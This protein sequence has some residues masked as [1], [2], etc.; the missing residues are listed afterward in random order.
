MLARLAESSA[1]RVRRQ[2]GMQGTRCS[3]VPA[4]GQVCDPPWTSW[5]SSCDLCRRR[6]F[7]LACAPPGSR[8]HGHVLHQHLLP[9]HHSYIRHHR[10]LICNYCEDT[11]ARLQRALAN[12]GPCYPIAA[13]PWNQ[14]TPA[15]MCQICECAGGLMSWEKPRAA[16]TTAASEVSC[17]HQT[18]IHTRTRYGCTK[19]P[20]VRMHE[21]L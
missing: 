9:E 11:Q 19:T 15:C 14:A 21:L 2:S 18:P 6:C 7:C 5:I 10:Q 20:R 13:L 12:H 4:S 1:V 3:A 17:Q 8:L 16:S